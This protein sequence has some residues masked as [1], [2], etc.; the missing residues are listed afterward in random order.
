[1]RMGRRKSPR[2]HIFSFYKYKQRF[3]IEWMCL[4]L[5]FGLWTESYSIKGVR[6]CTPPRWSLWTKGLLGS[7][8]FSSKEADASSCEVILVQPYPCW[9][10]K[11]HTMYF[12][13]KTI[14][15]SLLFVASW[16]KETYWSAIGSILKR[17]NLWWS[18]RQ[19][20]QDSSF[21]ELKLFKCARPGSTT[22]AANADSLLVTWVLCKSDKNTSNEMLSPEVHAG[23]QGLYC[24][25]SYHN[26][27]PSF[28]K[29]E[30]RKQVAGG[31]LDYVRE[32]FPIQ[33]ISCRY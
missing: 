19:W 2:T 18:N 17:K 15:P 5:F 25:F 7:T 20:W 27:I 13:T 10:C 8:V 11:G 9:R 6:T 26:T 3:T 16:S 14:H 32:L 4:D 22:I 23:W 12:D 28:S 21:S 31:I 33:K 29:V 30:D 24:T 1:M